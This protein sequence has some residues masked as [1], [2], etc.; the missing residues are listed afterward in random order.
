MPCPCRNCEK[1]DI[2]CHGSCD[3]YKAWRAWRD[4]VNGW[5]RDQKINTSQHALEVSKRKIM[6]KARGYDRRR[7][8]MDE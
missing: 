4:D 7:V 8:D 3:D 1:R 6:R 2:G 5:L